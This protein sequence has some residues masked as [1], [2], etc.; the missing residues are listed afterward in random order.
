MPNDEKQPKGSEPAS[1]QDPKPVRDNPGSSGNKN[2]VYPLKHTV[3][4]STTAAL[5]GKFCGAEE[6]TDDERGGYP[7]AE[8]AHRSAEEDPA[9]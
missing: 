8:P 9:G 1:P 5:D 6:R 3:T 2:P 7:E 4:K